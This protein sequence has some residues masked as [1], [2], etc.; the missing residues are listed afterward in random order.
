MKGMFA[1]SVERLAENYMRYL[2]YH[3]ICH[4]N[5]MN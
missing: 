2:E 1:F 5:K 4:E 3:N